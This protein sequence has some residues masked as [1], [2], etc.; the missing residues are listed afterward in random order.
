MISSAPSAP[1]LA[2]IRRP[3]SRRG[4]IVHLARLGLA[5]LLAG[6]TA[7][8]GSIYHRTGARFAAD[9]CA[10]LKS[11]MEEARRAE[12]SAEDADRTLRLRLNDARRHP[13]LAA[14]FDRVEL[15][16]FELDRRVAAA[17]DAMPQCPDAARFAGELD[18]L[19]TRAS[20]LLETVRTLRTSPGTVS[21]P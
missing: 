20:T 1:G 8:C 7:A 4:L 9:P 6:S 14:D 10:R 17:Q 5:L 16:A 19:H 21:A 2:P 13:A 12:K 18:R 3:R 15:A 11:R